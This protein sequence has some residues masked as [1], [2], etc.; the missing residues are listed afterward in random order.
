M[1]LVQ[2]DSGAMI[3]ICDVILVRYSHSTKRQIATVMYIYLYVLAVYFVPY[4]IV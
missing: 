3:D 1:L 2:G 4:F